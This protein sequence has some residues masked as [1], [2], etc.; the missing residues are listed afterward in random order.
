M[1][2]W[3][4]RQVHALRHLLAVVSGGRRGHRDMAER[5]AQGRYRQREGEKDER[6]PVENSCHEKRVA[7]MPP[8][9]QAGVAPEPRHPAACY[10]QHR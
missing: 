4:A 10:A 1:I 5:A 3:F 6:Q 9:N 8:N 7:L 2:E